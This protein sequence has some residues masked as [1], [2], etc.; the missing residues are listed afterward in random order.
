MITIVCGGTRL[1]NN[2]LW[3]KDI[4]RRKHAISYSYLKMDTISADELKFKHPFSMLLSGARRTGK[5]HFE[6][7]A[8]NEAE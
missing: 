4:N 6:K 5:T 7:N 1:Q 8:T 2:S 3:L